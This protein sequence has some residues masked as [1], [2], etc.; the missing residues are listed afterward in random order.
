VYVVI[1]AV[2]YPAS[3]IFDAVLCHQ[4]SES[5]RIRWYVVDTLL[6]AVLTF[7]FLRKSV[8]HAHDELEA[9]VDQE[10]L[11][12]DGKQRFGD[13]THR[14]PQTDP[15]PPSENARRRQT[16]GHRLPLLVRCMFSSISSSPLLVRRS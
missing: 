15:E 3:A 10:W 5:Q 12:G 16:G 11:A 1:A 14:I 7:L 6:I 4:Y 2:Q 9:V 13:L 8:F